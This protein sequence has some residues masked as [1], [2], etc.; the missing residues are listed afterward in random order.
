[1]AKSMRKMLLLAKLQASAGVDAGPAAATNAILLRNATV[2][3]V[4]VEYAERTLLRPYMGSPGQLVATRYAQIEGE[5]ELAG[6]GEPGAAP[7]WG[8]LLRGCG[9]KETVVEDTSVTYTPVSDG[10]EALTLHYYLDGVLHKM[11]DAKGTVSFDLTA[12]GTPFM[13]YRFMGAYAPIIDA[14]NPSDVDYS[15]FLKPLGVS[16]ANTP[17]W[18]LGGYTGCLQ[19]LT[20]DVANQLVWRALVSCEGAEIT[21][22]QPTGSISF[23]LPTI[24]QLNWPAIVLSAEEQAISVVHGLT[25]GNVIEIS[26]PKSQL[27]NPQYS[28]QDG[29]V[30]LG[31][32]LNVNP[33]QG[34]DEIEIVVR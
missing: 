29:I 10:F 21:D 28:D 16:K 23:E 26:L 2:T 30:M 9:F 25:A 27:T 3:P 5:V 14:A 13:R 17:T 7:A 32:T 20:F 11:L 4:S 6:C 18:S 31:L 22:R 8:P 24:A 1:M 34:N 19:S 33:N 15:A 12:K